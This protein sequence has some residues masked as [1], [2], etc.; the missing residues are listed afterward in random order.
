MGVKWVDKLF[1]LVEFESY[2][3]YLKIFCFNY[4]R[5]NLGFGVLFFFVV[6]LDFIGFLNLLNYRRF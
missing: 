6:L 2:V 5:G 1:V 3:I 4:K